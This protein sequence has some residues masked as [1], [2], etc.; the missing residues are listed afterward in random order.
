MCAQDSHKED[1]SPAWCTIR[2]ASLADDPE[3]DV[4]DSRRQVPVFERL[5]GDGIAQDAGR[6]HEEAFE[7]VRALEEVPVVLAVHLGVLVPA[8]RETTKV[9]H[10][11]RAPRLA[12]SDA[13]IVVTSEQF[14]ATI[15]R[16]KVRCVEESGQSVDAATV[17][18]T[19]DAHDAC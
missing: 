18:T 2:R 16:T 6:V 15:P 3:L 14:T 7:R 9:N 12:G 4:D 17:A 1:G 11:Q 19:F 13:Q 10:R 8:S 5:L